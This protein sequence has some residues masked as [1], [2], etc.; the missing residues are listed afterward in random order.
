MKKFT[1]PGQLNLFDL[2]HDL[3][4][5]VAEYTGL[6]TDILIRKTISQAIKACSLSRV[7]I[8][9]RMTELLNIEITKTMLDSWTAES[10]EGSNRF[11]A[12]YIPAFCHAVRSI[13]PLK[14][15]AD[16]A[17]CVAVQGEEALLLE[18]FRIEEQEHKLAEKKRAIRAIMQGAK[19]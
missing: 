19:K 13:E 15:M 12:C 1:P 8:A 16:L 3:R 4:P 17:G 5:K 18:M 14:V 7:Q 6:T 11:P 2:I 10:R 9:A